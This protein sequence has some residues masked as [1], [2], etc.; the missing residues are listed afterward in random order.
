MHLEEISAQQKQTGKVISEA[1]EVKSKS[2]TPVN[3]NP[4]AIIY[5][6]GVNPDALELTHLRQQPVDMIIYHH[7]AMHS[8]LA[9]EGIIG[10]FIDSK[11]WLTAYH[12]IIMP[13]GVIHPFCRWDRAGNHCIGFNQQSLAIALHGNFHSI[14]DDDFSNHDGRYGNKKPTSAQ[15]QSAACLIELWIQLYAI[16]VNFNQNILPHCDVLAGKTVCPGNQFP[17]EILQQAI[18]RQ[19]QQSLSLRNIDNLRQQF[20]LKPYVMA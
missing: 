12:A 10:E 11:K 2:D 6:G 17:H 3:T 15:I 19:H 20:Q 1:R 7:T 4:F 16:P 18:L 14:T 13:D 9:F 8:G 5:Q